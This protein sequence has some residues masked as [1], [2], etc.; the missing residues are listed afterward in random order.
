MLDDFSLGLHPDLISCMKDGKP[1]ATVTIWTW[2]DTC[3]GSGDHGFCLYL[4]LESMDNSVVY[5]FFFIQN[6][7]GVTLYIHHEC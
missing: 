6:I 1:L 7:F 2:T 5:K 4:D 3:A